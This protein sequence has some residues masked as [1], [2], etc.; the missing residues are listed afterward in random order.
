M[1]VRSRDLTVPPPRRVQLREEIATDHLP[2]VQ[3]QL[4][5][6]V[7]QLA[8]LG[9]ALLLAQRG[10]VWLDDLRYGRPRTTQLSAYIGINET[11]G[12][13]T[14]FTAMNLNRRVVVLMLP[15]GEPAKAQSLTGPYL[16]GAREDLTPV[17]LAVADRNGDGAAD[18]TVSVKQEELI[19]LNT[20]ETLRLITAAE[21]EQLRSARP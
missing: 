19:Y 8:L 20:G 17:D 13:P 4:P 9:L 11:S 21:R 18:L 16:F 10:P 12:S 7:V 15:G 2:R 14:Q 1:A 5:P 6:F 3:R